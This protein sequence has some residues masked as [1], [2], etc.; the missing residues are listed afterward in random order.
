MKNLRLVKP[1]ILWVI[2]FVLSLLA[3]N[4][5]AANGITD[6]SGV[7]K[8]IKDYAS[9]GKWLVVMLW[10]SDCHVCNQEV[11]QYIAFHKSHADKD[12]LVLGVSLDGSEKKEDAQ[13]FLQKH[14]VN[15]PSLIG[16]PI[17]V[18]SLYQNLTGSGWVGTP[19]FMVYNP[20]GDLIGAQAGAVPPSIIE[21]F[22]ERESQAA[23]K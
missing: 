22:I 12:A 16:E 19:S 7:P 4:T 8:S 13:Q 5:F 10:A 14:Q 3:H 23:L 2:T 9:Q 17:D 21:S 15:F 1:T 20:K 6:F 18:A 11:H